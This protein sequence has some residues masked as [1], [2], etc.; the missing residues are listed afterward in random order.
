MPDRAAGSEETASIEAKTLDRRSCSRSIVYCRVSMARDL[1]VDN[2]D[3][4]D[5]QS[6]SDFLGLGNAV[7]SRPTEGTVLDYKSNDGGD[8]V[9]DIAA[10][11]NTAGG[12]LF[13]GV[14]S[15]KQ[16]RNAPVAIVGIPVGNGDLKTRLTAQVVSLITPRPDFE[17]GVI[18]VPNLTDQSVALIRVRAGSY[19]PYQYSKQ[20]RVRFRIRVQDAT[21]DAS[22]RDLESMFMR[23]DAVNRSSEA[24]FDSLAVTP[25]FPQYLTGWET[26][27]VQLKKEMP[28][29]TWAIRPRVSMRIRLDREFDTRVRALVSRHFPD[30]NLGQHWPPAM[31]GR[32][33]VLQWQAGIDTS[34]GGPPARWPRNYE[35]TADGGLRLSEWVERREL[36]G[37][38]SISDLAIS[39]LR[40]LKLAEEFYQSLESFGQLTILHSLRVSPDFKF[41]LN[42]PAEDGIYRDTDA[43]RI[44]PTRSTAEMSN[45]SYETYSLR[46]AERVKIVTDMMLVHLRE[47]RQASVDYDKLLGLVAACPI[48][49]PLI[50]FP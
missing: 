38:E 48:E 43:I 31:T 37:V 9:E 3:A 49:Q 16:K 50:Y 30:S 10:F 19:P 32:S 4:L 11:A 12:L 15:D 46:E 5:F 35:F 27:P 14:Q 6:L 42:F 24:A 36:S 45:V 21:R 25:L 47:L 22:L 26:P 33:H 20:D 8:W 29:H 13:L 23:R 41:V 44:L 1:F 40:F 2:L 39:G 28:Y 34:S 17:V 7:D 18:P